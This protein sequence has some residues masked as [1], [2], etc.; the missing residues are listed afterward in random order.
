MTKSV[1]MEHVFERVKLVRGKG[2]RRKGRL[3]IMSFVALLSGEGHTDAPSTASPF[4][5]HFAIAINDAM[6]D[7]ERQRLKLFAPRIVG[8]ND[9]LDA[10][11]V[12]VM[13]EVFVGEVVP[14]LCEDLAAEWLPARLDRDWAAYFASGDKSPQEFVC[15][16]ISDACRAEPGRETNHVAAVAAKLLS[17]CATSAPASTD[18]GW[19][20]SKAI[21]LLDRLCDV[22]PAKLPSCVADEQVARASNILDHT[23]MFEMVSLVIAEVVRRNTYRLTAPIAPWLKRIPARHSSASSNR[24]LDSAVGGLGPASVLEQRTM[25]VPGILAV[26]QAEKADKV[27]AKA[28]NAW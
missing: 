23:G 17:S 26:D 5:R 2:E 16:F 15:A 1:S 8:T 9:G 19:Y 18:D 11:R 6:P 7:V 27:Q 3:C 21:D 12:R 28:S 24:S 4:I 20:W 10:K 22:G 14:Q 13:H 25:V